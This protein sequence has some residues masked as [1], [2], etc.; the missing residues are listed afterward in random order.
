MLLFIFHALQDYCRQGITLGFACF[1]AADEI[2][3][4]ETVPVTVPERVPLP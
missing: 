2:K 3:V 4:S 1:Q